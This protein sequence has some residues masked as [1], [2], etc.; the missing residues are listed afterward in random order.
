MMDNHQ[1][2]SPLPSLFLNAPTLNCSVEKAGDVMHHLNAINEIKFQIFSD[3]YFVY[4][5]SRLVLERKKKLKQNQDVEL[6]NCQN[7]E[8]FIH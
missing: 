8:L 4:F 3:L 6:E 5:L 2:S 7:M 1:A